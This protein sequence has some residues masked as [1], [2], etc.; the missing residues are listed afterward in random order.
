MSQYNTKKRIESVELK[1]TAE[2]ALSIRNKEYQDL[3]DSYN[4]L[5]IMNDEQDKIIH[6]LLER[7]NVECIN[8]T[9]TNGNVTNIVEL[10]A[11]RVYLPL[12]EILGYDMNKVIQFMQTPLY[13]GN[14]GLQFVY[15]EDRKLKIN[16]IKYNKFMEV[17]L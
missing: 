1:V 17:I 5:R 3:E 13:Q 14:E 6:D 4:A 2:K 12:Q 10:D 11:V 16:K 9:I 7:Y 8:A 15:V